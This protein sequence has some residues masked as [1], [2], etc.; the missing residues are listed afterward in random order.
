M[1]KEVLICLDMIVVASACGFGEELFMRCV[2]VSMLSSSF[3]V[4]LASLNLVSSQ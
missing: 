2:H 3:V 1:R 4:K